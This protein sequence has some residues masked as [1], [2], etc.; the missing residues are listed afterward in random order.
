[1]RS[2]LVLCGLILFCVAA[3]AQADDYHAL[4]D[5]MAGE[6]ETSIQACTRLIERGGY[7][8]THAANL[9]T[10]RGKA[11][12]EAMD[13]DKAIADFDKAIDLAP[14][15]YCTY[16]LRIDAY[17]RTGQ[18][19]RAAEEAEKAFALGL[20]KNPYQWKEP[21]R[22]PRDVIQDY[23]SGSYDLAI[24]GDPRL[25]AAY[26]KRGNDFRAR[27][28]FKEAIGD[29]DKAIEL[30]PQ[31]SPAYYERGYAHK[32]AGTLDKAF[33]D[34]D[35]A[36]AL[37][38]RYSLAYMAR[39]VA[40]LTSKGEYD[41]AIADLDKA[42]GINP[43]LLLAYHHRG[44]A[45]FKKDEY[46]RAIADFSKTIEINPKGTLGYHHRGLAYEK[47]GDKHSAIIDYRR[48]LVIEPWH[49]GAKVNLKRL[50]VEP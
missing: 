8:A 13:Q 5:C 30:D 27:G 23:C 46:D 3:A 21:H 29:F 50:G 7:S 31:F 10:L 49:Y 18:Y 41:H 33:A 1:M 12:S 6:F 32:Q 28:K 17:K 22:P 2:P 37:N 19:A 9:Y 36:I 38:P 48:V 16:G 39:A 43:R 47:K 34:Y 24:K 42:I 26:V 44:V 4:N 45:Y 14:Q 15:S 11:H 40:Y 35:R 25:A 20:W